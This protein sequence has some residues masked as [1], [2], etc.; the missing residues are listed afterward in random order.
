MTIHDAMNMIGIGADSYFRGLSSLSKPERLLLAEKMLVD[1]KANAKRLMV[2]HHPDKGGDHNK[3]VKVGQ[4]LDVI[5][6]ETA[7]F[8]Q[9]LKAKIQ[10][11]IERRS[12]QTF[13]SIG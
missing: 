9:R 13:I 11:D 5:E 10:E 4:C 2:K 3:F 8:I 7:E 1:A 12:S 6:K